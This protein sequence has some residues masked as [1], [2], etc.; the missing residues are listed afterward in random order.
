MRVGEKAM[1]NKNQSGVVSLIVVSILAVVLGL[2]AVGFAKLTD[3]ELRQAS[4]RELSAQASYAAEA[5]LNDAIAYLQGPNPTPFPGCDWPAGSPYFVNDLSPSSPDAAKY[6]CIS[7]A[8][9]TPNLLYSLHAGQ[10]VT[11]KISQANLNK[12][13]FGWENQGQTHTGS[14]LSFSGGPSFGTLPQEDAASLFGTNPATTGLLRVGIYP[15]PNGLTSADNNAL[16]GLSRNYFLYPDAGSGSP[17]SVSF[18]ASNGGFVHGNC[19]SNGNDPVTGLATTAR[20]CN[21]FISN[22]NGSGNTYYLQLTAIYTSL[23]ITVQA[24]DSSSKAL[25][26]KGVQGSIDVTGQGSDVLQRI[27]ARVDLSKKYQFPDFALQSMDA[28]CKGFTVEVPA[29]GQYGGVDNSSMPN[30]DNSC[31]APDGG[32]SAPGS[33]GDLGPHTS[34]GGMGSG[35]LLNVGMNAYS[36]N[37]K[38]TDTGGFGINCYNFGSSGTCSKSFGSATTVTLYAN[39]ASGDGSN[40][41]SWSG[42]NSVSGH[43]CTVNVSG[44]VSVSAKFVKK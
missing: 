26:F 25:D 36:P 24:E 23:N 1:K 39:E 38:I 30:P 37:D 9:K 22:L 21:S 8:D 17:G 42:C 35:N 13:Y 18:G 12:L 20:Y 43:Y 3:R 14:A 44:I 29:P 5:G 19:K 34:A 4:D 33:G 2:V 32:G 28:I 41:D 16:A 40:F 10:S 6:T 11:V 7:I 31:A 27:R 15:V